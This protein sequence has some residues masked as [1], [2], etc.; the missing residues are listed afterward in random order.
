M[1]FVQGSSYVESS[2]YVEV[3]DLWMVVGMYAVAGWHKEQ[4]CSW[5]VRC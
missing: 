4:V 3:A 2:W 1:V 5:L